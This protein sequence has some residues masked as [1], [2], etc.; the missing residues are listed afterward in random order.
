MSPSFTTGTLLVSRIINFLGRFYLSDTKLAL[1]PTSPFRIA[2]SRPAP[3]TI[4]HSTCQARYLVV[5][6]ASFGSP[7]TFVLMGSQI[8]LPIMF[9]AY[10][11]IS[12]CRAVLTGSW[13]VLIVHM[14]SDS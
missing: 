9:L 13:T 2:L 3:D 10:V 6:L 12:F 14:C 4:G 11:V 5:I 1:F 7:T 8:G